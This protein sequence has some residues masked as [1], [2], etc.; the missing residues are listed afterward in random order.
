LVDEI[1]ISHLHMRRARQIE[2]LGVA[3]RSYNPSKKPN[4]R[5]WLALDE[6]E[7]LSLTREFHR[8]HGEFSALLDSHA[9][10]HAAVETQIALDTPKVRAALRRLQKQGLNRHDAVHAIGSV[11]AEHMNELLRSDQPTAEDA[12]ERYYEKLSMFNAQDWLDDT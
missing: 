2:L 12:N 5:E 9:A 10:I 3:M 6:G 4:R 8:S 1:Q 11:L 7:R